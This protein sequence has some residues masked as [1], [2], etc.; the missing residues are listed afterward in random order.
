M[1]KAF[2]D[3]TFALAVGELS[4]PMFSDSGVCDAGPPAAPAATA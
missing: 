1:Q 4:Q 3:A 2:E